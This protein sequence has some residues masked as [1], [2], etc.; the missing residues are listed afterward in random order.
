MHDA[1]LAWKRFKEKESELVAMSKDAKTN[2]S[3]T[4]FKMIDEIFTYILGWEKQY[5]ETEY[6]V[7]DTLEDNS[8]KKLF[9]DYLLSSNYNNIIVEAKRTGVFFEIPDSTSRKYSIDGVI[10]QNQ[11][12]R[13]FI[14]QLKGYM[15]KLGIPFGVLTNGYQFLVLKSP[16]PMLEKHIYVFRDIMDVRNNF[17][18]FWNLFNPGSNGVEYLEQELRKK[19]EI[20]SKPSFRRSIHEEL[21]KKYAQTGV[22]SIRWVTEKHIN[23]YFGDITGEENKHLLEK[24]YCDPSGRFTGFSNSLKNELLP[25]MLSSIQRVTIRNLLGESSNIGDQYVESLKSE[26]GNVFVL[27]GGVGAGKSTFVRYFYEHQLEDNVKQNLVWIVIDFLKYEKNVEQLEQYID[28]TILDTL[29]NNYKKYDLFSWEKT[30]QIYEDLIKEVES[31]M[32][33]SLRNN[34]VTRDTK[35]YERIEQAKENQEEHLVRVFKFLKSKGIRPCFVFDNVDQKPIDWQSKA[36]LVATKKARSYK[37]IVITAIRVENFF[38]LKNSSV[39]DAIEPIVFRIEPPGV[40]ELLEKRIMALAEYPQQA[41]FIEHKG[42]S[43][44]IPLDKFVL[45]L[46]N[47]LKS[48]KNGKNVEM[49]LENLSADNMRRALQLFKRFIQSGHTKLNELFTQYKK[50]KAFQLITTMYLKVWL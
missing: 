8:H 33:P 3:D 47:T 15:T 41:F 20:R 10:S 35:V 30:E 34:Q 16:H 25:P 36:L 48:K 27:V 39:F 19:E 5:I 44:K 24:C 2:E 46:S 49:L 6:S 32:P 9:A 1:D 50:S 45:V 43:I 17:S 13:K 4:R 29:R 22:G 31:G 21:V 18:F 37:A 11:N 28:N 40:K 42:I 7:G 14:Q 38:Q 26:E 23:R 12:N